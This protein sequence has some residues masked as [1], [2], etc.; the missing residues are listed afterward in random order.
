MTTRNQLFT[1]DGD[2][3]VRMTL[4]QMT[5]YVR[6]LRS[7]ATQFEFWAR[8]YNLATDPEVRAVCLDNMERFGED[9]SGVGGELHQIATATEQEDQS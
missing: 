3:A 2:K 1:Y 7:D 4:G 9:A 5:E 8:K 6:R